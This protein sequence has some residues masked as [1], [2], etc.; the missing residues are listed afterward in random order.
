MRRQTVREGLRA[1][2]VAA[3]ASAG[4]LWE[5]GRVRGQALE[6]INAIAHT[7]I[8]SRAFFV[9]QW[10]P[11]VTL[12]AL[13]IHTASVCAWGVVIALL[14]PKL[15]GGRLL[16][17]VVLCSAAIYALETNL[18]PES[19]RPGFERILTPREVGVVYFAFALALA[20]MLHH[21]RRRSPDA[22]PGD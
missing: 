8:G 7:L 18:L 5:F 16:L 3:A 14:V 9:T 11:S 6:P 15:R 20:A 17:A 2:F 4:A 19:L 22:L 21:G 13:V 12:T 1:G 10:Q